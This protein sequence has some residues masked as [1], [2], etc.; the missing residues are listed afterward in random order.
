MMDTQQLVINCL[1]ELQPELKASADTVLYGPDGNL[2]SFQLV[3]LL[4]EVE[5]RLEEQQ[6][7]SVTVADDKA[8]SRKNSPFRTVR[9]LA[10]YVRELIRENQP[11]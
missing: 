7:I 3:T 6:G 11:S 10:E 5:T 8:F 9:A 1:Q 4:V 2:N